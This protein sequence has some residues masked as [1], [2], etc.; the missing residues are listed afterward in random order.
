MNK[1][2][3]YLLILMARVVV[4]LGMLSTVLFNMP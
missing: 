4:I 2:L 3:E 1:R